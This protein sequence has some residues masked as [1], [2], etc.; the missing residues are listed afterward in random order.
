[1][2]SR[3]Q[4]VHF[5]EYLISIVLKFFPLEG[6]PQTGFCSLVQLRLLSSQSRL[7]NFSPDGYDR[8]GSLS[9]NLD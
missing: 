3:V 7:A 8:Y 9:F 2:E 1:M 4:H 6:I 5:P